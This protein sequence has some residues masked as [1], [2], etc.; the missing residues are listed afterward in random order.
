M[1][2]HARSSTVR[3][4]T[5]TC[6]AL[7]GDML[8][9][10]TSASGSRSATGPSTQSNLGGLGRDDSHAAALDGC[11]PV[12]TGRPATAAAT[13]RISSGLPRIP[14]APRRSICTDTPGV[15][16]SGW[17]PGPEP[18]VSRS[19]ADHVAAGTP[20]W[21]AAITDRHRRPDRATPAADA[22]TACS[23]GTGHAQ[24]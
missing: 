4:C 18:K 20:V 23:G 13:I 16:D 11:R 17:Q 5:V 21:W 24:P 19:S 7:A 1:N 12:R 14:A 6:S 15:R 2:S 8:Q 10:P 22:I 9:N 3:I